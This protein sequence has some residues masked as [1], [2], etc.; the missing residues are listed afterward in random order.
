ML[1]TAATDMGQKKKRIKVH[2]VA[3]CARDRAAAD[4]G[5]CLR[6]SARELPR[7][8]GREVGR[9]EGVAAVSVVGYNCYLRLDMYA[10]APP[11]SKILWT[12]VKNNAVVFILLAV[13]VGIVPLAGAAC[14]LG[15]RFFCVAQAPPLDV[16]KGRPAGSRSP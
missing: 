10:P 4:C 9:S 8:W 15:R 14:V 16:P 2:A 13:I 5:E 11:F 3:Q 1:A 12:F 6:E 7:C